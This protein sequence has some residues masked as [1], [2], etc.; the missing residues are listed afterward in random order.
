MKYFKIIGPTTEENAFVATEYEEL[1]TADAR[2][3]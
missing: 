2:A 1:E 3:E